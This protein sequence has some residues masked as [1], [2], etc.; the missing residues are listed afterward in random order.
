MRRHIDSRR[1]AVSTEPPIEAID[2]GKEVTSPT[3]HLAILSHIS[4]V[5]E[6][7]ETVALL[8][9]SGSGKSTL[10]TLL[11]G[12][13]LPTQGQARLFGHPLNTLNEDERAA[14]RAGRVGFVFQDFNLLP[15][16]TAEENV[17]IAAELAGTQDVAARVCAS[18][19]AV[20]LTERA[21][22]LPAMLSGGE[23]QRVAIARAWVATPELLIADEPTG[24]LDSK[25]G[26]QVIQLLFDLNASTRTTLLLATH[27]DQL[28]ARCD[29][30]LRLDAGQLLASAR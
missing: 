13:D 22:H 29:R 15:R 24:N 10:L 1:T 4:F 8:G 27:D 30:R 14:L 12:L 23:Q 2:V 16:L 26:A 25:T 6:R 20:G 17:R 5:V 9:P 11:A 18:L 21:R 3:G 28:A 19:E 7:G